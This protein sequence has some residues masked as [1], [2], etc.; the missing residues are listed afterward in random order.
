MDT[1]KAEQKLLGTSPS[2][3]ALIEASRPEPPKQFKKKG[4][5]GPNPLSVKKK[6]PTERPQLDPRNKNKGKATEAMSAPNTDRVNLG[7]RKRNNNDNDD[8]D[9]ESPSQKHEAAH[10]ESQAKKRRRRRKK[11]LEAKGNTEPNRSLDED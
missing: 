6:K 4:R 11:L 10:L 8:D 7:K 9:R 1:L 2:D 5:K 3:A